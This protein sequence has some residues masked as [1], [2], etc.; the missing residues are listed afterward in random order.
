MSLSRRP[1]VLETSIERET[2]RSWKKFQIDLGHGQ[3]RPLGDFGITWSW[4][5]RFGNIYEQMEQ[6][7]MGGGY[8]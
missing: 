8:S 6:F 2:G 7:L 3:V 1:A 4:Y 5:H